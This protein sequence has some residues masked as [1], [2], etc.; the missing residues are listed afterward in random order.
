MIIDKRKLVPPADEVKAWLV[1]LDLYVLVGVRWGE[2]WKTKT[3]EIDGFS[4]ERCLKDF[5]QVAD[6][7]ASAD[8][9]AAG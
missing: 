1:T 4:A 9:T 7:M 2:T 5:Q 6:D 3:F 8:K